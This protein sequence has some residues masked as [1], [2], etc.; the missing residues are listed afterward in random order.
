[1]YWRVEQWR[2]RTLYEKASWLA[3]A[4]LLCLTIAVELV[5]PIL[6]WRWTQVPFLDLLFEH[7]LLVSS[8]HR[9]DWSTNVTQE[10]FPYLVAVGGKPVT[11][12]KDLTQVLRSLSPGQ[13]VTLTLQRRDSAISDLCRDHHPAVPSQGL[14]DHVLAALW[15]QPDL[16]G[17]RDMGLLAARRSTSRPELCHLLRLCR[18]GHR[19]PVRHQFQPHPD[20]HLGGVAALYPP[21]RSCTWPLS[22]PRK[23]L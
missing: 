23:A 4:L 8:D 14:A 17:H 6:S 5:A 2:Q 10:G 7:T 3:V 15:C 18:P 22:F 12:D 11:G 13:R 20:A 19:H 9:S 1:M 21:P 16:P